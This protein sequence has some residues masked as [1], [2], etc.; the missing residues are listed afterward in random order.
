M[1]NHYI[2]IGTILGLGLIGVIIILLTI[3]SRAVPGTGAAT[4][5]ADKA[6][7]HGGSIDG[8]I[9]F[10]RQGYLWSWRGDKAT[11]M[12]I[13]PGASTVQSNTVQLIQPAL[14]VDGGK[15]AFI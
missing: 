13:E 8:Q 15:L 14:S 5:V 2:I 12:P 11:R 4:P 9:V 7:L 1:R 6:E 3:P 10:S